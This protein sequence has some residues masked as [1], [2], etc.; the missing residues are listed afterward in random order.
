[1]YTTGLKMPELSKCISA[2]ASSAVFQQKINYQELRDLNATVLHINLHQ[3]LFVCLL[4]LVYH[5][6]CLRKK[7]KIIFIPIMEKQQETEVVKILFY[8][9]IDLV[10]ILRN[11][12]QLLLQWA[13]VETSPF[14]VSSLSSQQFLFF[15]P[16]GNHFLC[17]WTKV[18]NQVQ[19]K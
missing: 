12:S 2:S 13:S 7:K 14:C 11:C 15:L 19:S 6:L 9:F 3:C 10:Y 18:V 17:E 5:R 1:M 8:A 16:Y 4:L